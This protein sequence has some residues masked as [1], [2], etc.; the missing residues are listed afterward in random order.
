MTVIPACFLTGPALAELPQNLTK[1]DKFRE[2]VINACR[3]EGS[4]NVS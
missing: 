1:K 3:M 2:S 4:S